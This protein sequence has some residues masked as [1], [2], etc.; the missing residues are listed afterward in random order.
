MTDFYNAMGMTAE[1]TDDNYGWTDLTGIRVRK[2]RDGYIL[3]LPR[4]EQLD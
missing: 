4:T 2:I 3:D 1:F